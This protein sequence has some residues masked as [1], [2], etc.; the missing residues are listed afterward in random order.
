MLFLLLTCQT[1][2]EP[3]PDPVVDAW[4]EETPDSLMSLSPELFD[5]IGTFAIQTP[6]D[7]TY[8]RLWKE[9][10]GVWILIKEDSQDPGLRAGHRW[11]TNK[12]NK[13][14]LMLVA[15]GREAK[16]DT[17]YWRQGCTQ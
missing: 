10:K 16:A 14:H 2:T 11:Y 5:G 4:I 7:T 15:W 6:P 17:A 12:G 1:P 8:W 9:I 3:L 13:L